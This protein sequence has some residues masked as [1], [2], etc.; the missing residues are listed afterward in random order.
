MI[1]ESALDAFLG[2]YLGDWICATLVVG[3]LSSFVRWDR[4]PPF[5]LC[6]GGHHIPSELDPSY[7]IPLMDFI[8]IH[9]LGRV[10]HCNYHGCLCGRR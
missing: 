4:F 5:I 8:A 7:Q 6:L 9:R 10:W 1:I 2:E 3:S